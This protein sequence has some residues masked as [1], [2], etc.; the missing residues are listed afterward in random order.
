MDAALADRLATS[1]DPK[2]L[3]ELRS[4][5]ANPAVAKAIAGQFG[6]FLMQGLFQDS[7]G[8]AI[9]MAGGGTGGPEVSAMFA[10]TIGRYAAGQDQLGLANT[11]YKSMMAEQREKDSAPAGAPAP[12]AATTTPKTAS[13][14]GHAHA[15]ALGPYWQ[16]GGH[17][18]LG[19]AIRHFTIPTA[20]TA[21]SRTAS[22][23]PK[24]APAPQPPTHRVAHTGSSETP[25]PSGHPASP[26][27]SGTVSDHTA[28][29]GIE[30]RHENIPGWGQILLPATAPSASTPPAT[31][32]GGATPSQRPEWTTGT[33]GASGS[34]DHRRH[35]SGAVAA[36]ATSSRT[37]AEH[38]AEEMAPALHQAA[39]RLGVSPRVLLAQ[40]ALETGWGRSVVGNNVFGIKAG[41]SWSGA[42][43]EARTHETENGQSV[44]ERGSFRSYANV[45]QAVDDYVSLV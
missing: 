4:N 45:T 39:A 24:S 19:P 26:P 44:A 30:W 42:T 29:T 9:P 21:A 32:N 13:A 1:I 17:R 18:P 6:A 34:A 23:T 31:A 22:A 25:R 33:V 38:F 8:N 20:A 5:D 40:A 10:S 15:L 43:V 27:S 37:D 41:A 11:I 28:G 12:V 3:A 7:S 16:D 2:A 14:S 35:Q 36:P